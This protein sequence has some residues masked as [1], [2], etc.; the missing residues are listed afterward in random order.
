MKTQQEPGA[1]GLTASD[2]KAIND[3]TV[4]VKVLVNGAL[5]GGCHHAAGKQMEMPKSKADVLAGMTPP[6]VEVIGVS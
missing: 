3:P 4:I 2:A 6:Q 1:A 5:F